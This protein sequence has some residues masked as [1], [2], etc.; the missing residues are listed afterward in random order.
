LTVQDIRRMTV[1]QVVDFVISYNERQEQ[2]EKARKRSEPKDTK[3]KA[4]QD[5]INAFFG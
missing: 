2:S 1:G 3:R 4:T 5:D